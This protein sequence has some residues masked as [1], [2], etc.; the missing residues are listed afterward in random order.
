MCKAGA[1]PEAIDARGCQ[2]NT[3]GQQ[4]SGGG[5]HEVIGDW[6]SL[7]EAHAIQSGRLAPGPRIPW[8]MSIM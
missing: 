2:L 4:G 8:L 7:V 5:V 1:C 6:R 3:A